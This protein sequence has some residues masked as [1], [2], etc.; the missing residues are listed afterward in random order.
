MCHLHNILARVIEFIFVSFSLGIVWY[1]A[2]VCH[3]H[4]IV[5][6]VIDLYLLS[7]FF[8]LGIVWYRALV[9]HYYYLHNISV[10]SLLF[11]EFD[12]SSS[13]VVY[14]L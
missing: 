11:I 6:R 3:L 4:N 12:T 13:I 2:L 7:F 1:R 5:A 14:Y 8:S 9:Y 10:V